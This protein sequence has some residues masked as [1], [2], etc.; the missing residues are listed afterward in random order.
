METECKLEITGD[1]ENGVHKKLLLHN[2]EF[3]FRVMKK[4]WEEW[5]WLRDIVNTIN[6]T[7]L[8]N[9]NSYNGKFYV[10]YILPQ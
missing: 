8:Y 6:A 9:I 4:F 5:W 2:T 7:E 1:W 3:L 10:M